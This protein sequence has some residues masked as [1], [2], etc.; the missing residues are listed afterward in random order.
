[1]R[2]KDL[3]RRTITFQKQTEMGRQRIDPGNFPW[4]FCYCTK[5]CGQL[6]RSRDL[7]FSVRA[8]RLQDARAPVTTADLCELC[9]RLRAA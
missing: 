8:V 9:D 7:I 3:G 5:K 2:G 6:L 1:M 4:Y